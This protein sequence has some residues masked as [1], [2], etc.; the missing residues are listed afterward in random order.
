MAAAA[1]VVAV[2]AEAEAQILLEGIEVVQQVRVEA[3]QLE[4]HTKQQRPIAI[5]VKS[6]AASSNKSIHSLQV[7][8]ALKKDLKRPY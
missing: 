7:W 1:V 6:S 3:G 2:A 4:R 5:A 8:H